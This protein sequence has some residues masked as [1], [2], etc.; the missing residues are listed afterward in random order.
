M[1][2]VKNLNSSFL[3]NIVKSYYTIWNSLSLKNSNPAYFSS[4]VT[5]STATSFCVNT[6][7][8][9][10]S[11]GVAWNNTSLIKM[12]TKLLFCISLIHEVFVDIVAIVDNS[13]G[14]IFNCFFFIL[15]NTL[16]VGDIQMSLVYSLL[17]TILPYVGS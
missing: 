10:N 3:G 2:I 15:W 12:E 13:V 7:D 11:Q 16:I 9:N 6:F 8:V 17:G 5:M 1:F 4:V 14:F